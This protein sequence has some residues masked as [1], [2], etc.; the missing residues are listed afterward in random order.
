MV[1]RVLTGA[2]YG[3]NSWIWQRVTAVI[4][5]ICSLVFF[6]F[7]TY[8]A[9]NIN[10]SITSWQAVFACVFVKTVVQIFFVAILIHAWVG[11]RDLWMDYIKCSG[12]R[13]TLHT[14]TILWLIGSLIYSIKVIWAYT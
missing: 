12:F 11:I 3:L 4:L 6:G 14:L 7:V 8:L 1:K 2:G 10:A 9:T 5:L 13:L